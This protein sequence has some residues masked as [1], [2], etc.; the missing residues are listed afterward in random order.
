MAHTHGQH[1]CVH[2]KH[3]L[4]FT[5]K[6]EGTAE[7]THP[8]Y[9]DSEETPSLNNSDAEEWTHDIQTL[10]CICPKK[11]VQKMRCQALNHIVNCVNESERNM[12][13]ANCLPCYP[14]NTTVNICHVWWSG[15]IFQTTSL[16]QTKD[17][18][19][20]EIWQDVNGT[21]YEHD[22]I[23]SALDYRSQVDFGKRAT[24]DARGVLLTDEIA[25]HYS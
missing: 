12:D 15:T 16:P 13:A 1:R 3:R 10:Y 18:S 4:D 20:Y 2:H 17:M 23:P 14:S 8:S 9:D 6:V 7:P 5:N 21:P 24:N 11:Q 19:F 25:G 22:Y